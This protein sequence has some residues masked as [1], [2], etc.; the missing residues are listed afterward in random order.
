M[1]WIA[2]YENMD[3]R[4]EAYMIF[5]WFLL[6]IPHDHLL[7]ELWTRQLPTQAALVQSCGTDALAPYRM[8]VTYNGIIICTKPA[9]SL[10]TVQSECALNGPLDQYRLRIVEPNYQTLIGCS[11]T[12]STKDEPS[13]YE[14]HKQ[15]PDAHDFVVRFSGSRQAD[16]VPALCK[17]PSLQQPVSIATSEN[18]YLLA[19]KLIWY[20]LAHAQ[21]PNGLSGVD[22][23]TFAATACGMDGARAKVI[24]WQNSLDQSIL[25]AAREWNVPADLLK[26]IIASESQF[27][28]WTGVNGEHGL[29]QITDDGAHVVLHMYEKGYYALSS[30]QQAQA[31]AAWLNSLDC[32]GCTPLQ[33]LEKAKADM[34]K[35]AQAL[36]AYYCMYGSWNEAARAWNIKHKEN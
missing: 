13:A 7:C 24:D 10:V 1:A 28:I 23:V 22:P 36:A 8:D 35:T 31:R 15:C 5:V 27:W 26:R 12:T 3:R 18:Y 11:V 32:F 6:T 34:P 20:G 14:I 2:N 16:P 21:C 25:T 9:A 4:P 30:T 19:G 17:P 29:A 33:T